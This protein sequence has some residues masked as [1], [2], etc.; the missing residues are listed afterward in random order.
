MA[1]RKTRVDKGVIKKGRHPL[2]PKT[3]IRI[4]KGVERVSKGR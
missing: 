4:K 1:E 2:E 3:I